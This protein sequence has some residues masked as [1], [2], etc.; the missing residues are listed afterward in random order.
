MRDL[1]IHGDDLIVGTHGRSFWILDDITPLR[2]FTDEVA[3]ALCLFCLPRKRLCVGAGTAI[4]TPRC[5]PKFRQG[6]IR[7][8]AR[9]LITIWRQMR[10]RPVTL[11]FC[12]P[13]GTPLVRHYSQHG[14]ASAIEKLAAEYPIPMYWV[15]PAQI[16]SAEA[17]MHRFVWDVHYPAPD[18]LEREFPI[19]AILHDT[20]LLPLGA[21]ALPGSYTVKLTV[22]G[23]SYTQPLTLKMDPRIHTPLEDLRKQQEMEI[24]AVEGVDD[25]YESLE[26]VKSARD[27]IK[28]VSKKVNG[29]EKLAK[30][31]AALDNQCAELEGGTQHSFY[32]VPASG[33]TPENFS[34]LNQHFAAILAVADSADAAPTTQ[35]EAAYQD[36]E[37][38]ET[39]LR[40]RWSAIREKDI[41][42]LNKGLT[43]E[44]LSPIDP[45]KPLEE[46]L[47][48]ASDGD[49]EP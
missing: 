7:R 4:P 47:G 39:G 42:E 12:T 10:N 44:G 26:Q 3:H 15:R 11:E 21:W 38:S 2:Q 40:R 17:G 1:T 31:L 18:A 41:P 14:Q 34:T 35:A 33:K 20:P 6:R 49:D 43:K 45:K 19:S 46:E 16:L 29:K 36:L 9:S 30:E 37:Q 24:G 28:E 22:N 25:S 8:T 27:Q 13:D 32:G 23:Q 48:G 5:R